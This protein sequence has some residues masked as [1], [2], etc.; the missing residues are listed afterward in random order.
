M[1]RNVTYFLSDLHLG[2]AYFRDPIEV[3]KRAV[4]F[5]RSIADSAE[6]I[7][8]VGDVLD[9]WFE[10]RTVVP[11][12]FIRFF[13]ALAD[14]ADSGVKITWMIGNHDIWI[15]DYLPSQLGIEVVDGVLLREICGKKFFITHGDGVGRNP[16]A[17]RFLRGMFRNRV[18]QK[19]FSA[20]HPRLTIPFAFGWSSKNRS[21]HPVADIYQGPDREPLMVFAREYLSEHPDIDYFVFGHRHIMVQE[22]LSAGCTAVILGEW[23]DTCSYAVITPGSPLQLLTWKQQ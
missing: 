3:E 19:L 13:G 23:I 5:L 10:Y 21:Q 16:A 15:F 14:L 17:F 18:C 22:P 8:L 9:F 11:R 20:I 12:G 7:Y 2:A 6:A 4:A 1:P